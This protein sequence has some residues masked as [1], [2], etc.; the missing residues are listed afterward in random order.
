[1]NHQ[2]ATTSTQRNFWKENLS[3]IASS[4]AGSAPIVPLL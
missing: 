3:Y 2:P 1:M 4:I